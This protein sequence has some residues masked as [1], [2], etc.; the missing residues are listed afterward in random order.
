MSIRDPE[1]KGQFNSKA[2][3]L[4]CLDYALIYEEEFVQDYEQATLHA[5]TEHRRATLASLE[6]ELKPLLKY[7]AIYCR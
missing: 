5:V 3:S 6:L 2:I 1:N 4:N 7:I